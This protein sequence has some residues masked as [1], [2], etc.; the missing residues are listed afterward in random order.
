M[1]CATTWA[2]THVLGQD[3]TWREKAPPLARHRR[4]GML[5]L[6]ELGSACARA[7]AALNF[8]VA[9]WSRREKVLPGIATHHGADGLDAVLARSDILVLLVPLTADTEGLMSAKRIARL[10][11]GAVIVNPGRGPLIDDDA[12]I[13]ALDAGH[14]SHATLDVFRVEPLPPSHPFW[15]HPRVTVTPHIASTTRPETAA[16]VIAENIRRGEAGEPFLHRVDRGAG[17]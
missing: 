5:G 2:S 4:V 13:A 12:L 16:G 3:G 11:K 10:P 1:C 7:L 14:L 8:D 9:G 17:Y 15:A 6:G